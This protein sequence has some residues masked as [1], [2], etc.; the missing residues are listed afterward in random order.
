MVTDE[1][2]RHYTT[3]YNAVQTIPPGRVT[4]YGYIAKLI[5]YP[6]NARQIGYALKQLPF[7][8]G[9]LSRQFHSD[10][11]PWWRVIGSGGIVSTRENP[12]DRNRQV[13][14]LRS[15][16]IIAVDYKVSMKTFAWNLSNAE[17]DEIMDRFINGTDQ[18]ER[19]VSDSS[20]ESE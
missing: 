9:Q 17:E 19:E 12:D 2:Q 4:T 14:M 11:V 13:E 20:E 16:G 10:N 1:A 3:I 7:N 8:N 18:M 5:G 6:R 15:E